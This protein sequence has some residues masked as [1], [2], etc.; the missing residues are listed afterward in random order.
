MTSRGRRT[1][2]E[3]GTPERFPGCCPCPVFPVKGGT[4]PLNR[5]SRGIR[6]RI[7]CENGVSRGMKKVKTKGSLDSK[8]HSEGGEIAEA[9]VGVGRR[10]EGKSRA[11]ERDGDTAGSS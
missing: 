7:Q 9:T 1:C 5:E 3:L 11:A 8:S 4:K 10:M 6:R 2:R